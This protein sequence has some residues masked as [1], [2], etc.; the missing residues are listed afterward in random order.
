M[1]GVDRKRDGLCYLILSQNTTTGFSEVTAAH[2][3]RLNPLS[4]GDGGCDKQEFS[5]RIGEIHS[6]GR[7]VLHLVRA[8]RGL[9]KLAEHVGN[10]RRP[11]RDTIGPSVSP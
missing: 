11:A 3:C 10:G 6:P 2:E 7:V 1:I 4:E 9:D 5:T 8:P